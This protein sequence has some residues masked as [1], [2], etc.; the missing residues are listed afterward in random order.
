MIPFTTAAAV[1]FLAVGI[2]AL[3]PTVCSWIIDF[4]GREPGI[5]SRTADDKELAIDFGNRNAESFGGHVGFSDPYSFGGKAYRGRANHAP[6][7]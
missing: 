1:F 3:C 7:D 2:S 6:N 5:V 4:D